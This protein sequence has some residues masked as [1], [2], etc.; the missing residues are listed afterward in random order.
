MP[1]TEARSGGG[2]PDVALKNL[3]SEVSVL[4]HHSWWAAGK[5]SSAKGVQTETHTQTQTHT[6]IARQNCNAISPFSQKNSHSS[7]PAEGPSSS[8]SN[9]SRTA[10]GPLPAKTHVQA[11]TANRTLPKQEAFRKLP[12]RQCR[13]VHHC[14]LVV[15]HPWSLSSSKV[16]LTPGY[17]ALYSGSACTLFGAGGTPRSDSFSLHIIVHRFM[18]RRALAALRA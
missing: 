6:H 18:Q 7:R 10:A 3:Q 13:Q 8:T 11:H 17:P 15:S 5:S 1:P 12:G 16:L 14:L 4:Q 2:T 9:T